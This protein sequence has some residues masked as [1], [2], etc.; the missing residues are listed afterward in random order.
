MVYQHQNVIIGF[1]ARLTAEEAKAMEEKDNVLF[2]RKK[3]IL[4]FH[5]THSPKL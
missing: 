5:T 2:V 1:A 4:A 3:T